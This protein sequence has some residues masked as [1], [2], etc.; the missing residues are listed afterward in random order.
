MFDESTSIL[1]PLNFDPEARPR[2]QDWSGELVE[3]GMFYFSKR[4]LIENGSFQ[5]ERYVFLLPN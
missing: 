4:K 2:K 1:K 5:N 3:N